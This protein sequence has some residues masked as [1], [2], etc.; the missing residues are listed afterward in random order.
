MQR[1]K[2]GFWELAWKRH[3]KKAIAHPNVQCDWLSKQLLTKLCL[4][5]E[6]LLAVVLPVCWIGYREKQCCS[7]WG[8][9]HRWSLQKRNVAAQLTAP[10]KPWWQLHFFLCHTPTWLTWRRS[11]VTSV[12]AHSPPFFLSSISGLQDFRAGTT[13][14]FTCRDCNII[15]SVFY[16]HTVN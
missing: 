9:W 4:F 8:I 10:L 16:I 3:C 11:A 15:G 7:V 5:W 2:D 13:A 14:R 1:D 6:G 12:T